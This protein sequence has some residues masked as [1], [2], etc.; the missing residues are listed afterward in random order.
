VVRP[1]RS[2]V[3]VGGGA[4]AVVVGGDLGVPPGYPRVDRIGAV[5]PGRALWSASAA[6]LFGPPTRWDLWLEVLSIRVLAV[7]A[8]GERL[9]LVLRATDDDGGQELRFVTVDGASGA[10]GAVLAAVGLAPL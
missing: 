5:A 8:V 10:S 9:V 4:A 3:L 2:L 6:D 1:D 7:E